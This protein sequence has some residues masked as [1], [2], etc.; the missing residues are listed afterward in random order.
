M[1]VLLA[2]LINFGILE[3]N[4]E[5][6][7]VKAGGWSLYR[8]SV[9]I[10]LLASVLCVGLF[11]VQDYI[12][13]TANEK[14]DRIWNK[15][16]NRAPQTT[17]S[18]RKWILGESGRIYNYEH[19][20]ENEDSFVGLNI[21]EIDLASA[22]MLRRIHAG[23]AHIIRHGEWE[24]ANGWIRDYTRVQAG[25]RILN[26]AEQFQFPESADYFEKEI[27]QPKESSKMT[28][29][30]LKSHIKYLKE[31]GYNAVELQVELYKKISFPLSCLTMTLLA[32]P[33]SFIIGRRGAFFGIGASIAIAMGYMMIMG[34]F[35]AMGSYGILNPFLAAWS[36][37]ILFGAA[38]FWLFLSIRT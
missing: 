5:I 10:F 22:T 20:D 31:S 11:L 24:L 15:I 23:R 32:I 33:F 19:F 16:K 1:S 13:P 34:F 17:I 30:K 9:P 28:Y 2:I 3:K 6:T 37:N 27:F 18:T 7:A 25:F 4:S 26:Q 12:L 29:Y 8:I 36:P 14:Q 35:E 21:Y 38:G